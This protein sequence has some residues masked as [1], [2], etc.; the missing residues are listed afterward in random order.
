MPLQELKTEPASWGGCGLTNNNQLPL[1]CD[2]GKIMK[3]NMKFKWISRSF[4]VTATVL[5][6]GLFLSA[7]NL[8]EA[9]V[10]TPLTLFNGW[11]NAP[12]G[13]NNSAIQKF[14]GI[15]YFKGAIAS[16]TSTEPFVLPVGFR[17][18]T[19]VYVPIDLCN[20]QKGRL[21][22]E[23]TGVVHVAAEGAFANAQC[24]TSLDGASFARNA[25]GF[26]PL[27]LINGWTNAPFSTSNA[28]F[29]NISGIVHF[30]GAIA[31]SGTNTA[32]FVLPAGIRP[33]K[34]K[35]VP[36]DL[37][38]AANGRL[39]INP[40]GTVIVQSEKL[41]SSAQCFTSLDGAWYA[42]AA[43]PGFKK[44]TLLN[45]WTNTIYNTAPAAANA[46]H[47]K[48][49]VRLRGAISTSGVSAQP[50]VLPLADR[51]VTNV[52][53]NIDLCNATKGRLFIQSNGTVSVQAE[54]SFS[55]A[56]C[57]TS[58]EGASFVQ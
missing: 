15:V 33:D 50:F 47:G 56:Q 52:Y 21:I 12:F 11:T 45:G 6:G 29:K 57:F 8:V 41:F 18:A 30:K 54:T 32:P 38:N 17:P 46:A 4:I 13:T 51:P 34:V 5:A 39:I 48:V 31:T 20:A 36:V 2:Q 7:S 26:T 27:T 35:Y 42:I 22:I 25:A 40:N 49:P 14:N 23:P 19:W 9:A 3:F 53:I 44:L 55:N 58:L 24:F 10:A 37:C 28:A 1:K 16:G 43:A